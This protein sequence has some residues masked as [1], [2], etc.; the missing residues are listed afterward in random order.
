MQMHQGFRQ[1]FISTQRRASSIIENLRCEE[2]AERIIEAIEDFDGSLWPPFG[3][4]EEEQ[5]LW[6]RQKGSVVTYIE[7]G[8]LELSFPERVESGEEDQTE[9]SSDDIEK[10]GANKERV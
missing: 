3:T 5:E 10:Y 4:P 1:G 2:N 7:G 9:E 8:K 6:R